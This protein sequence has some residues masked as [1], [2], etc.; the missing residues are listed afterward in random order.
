MM[1]RTVPNI[2]AHYGCSQE[3]AQR[4]MDLRDEGYPMHQALLMAGLSDPP[5]DEPELETSATECYFDPAIAAMH[6]SLDYLAD[7]HMTNVAEVL[8]RPSALVS[9]ESG[10]HPGERFMRVKFTRE[11]V[12]GM[13]AWLEQD[14]ADTV[15]H[16]GRPVPLPRPVEPQPA[17]R[18]YICPVRTVADLANNLLMMDQDLPIYGAQYI[19]HH[20][21][22]R[23]VA[24]SPTVSRERVLASRWIGEGDTLNAAVVWTRAEQPTEAIPSTLPER[25]CSKPSEEQGLF[26]KF[27]VQRTDGSSRPGGRHHDC[28]YFVLDVDHDPHAPAALQAYAAACAESH[29]QLSADLIA[30]HGAQPAQEPLSQVVA[31]INEYYAAL[32]QRKHGGVAQDNAF[33]QIQLALGMT[34]V[35]GASAKGGAA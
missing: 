34:W 19:E 17:E 3:T 20:G 31:A 29:P 9:D 6:C 1:L 23:C 2:V 30:R 18:V 25:D 15:Q 24:V 27:T 33:G 4:Y 8:V 22:R 5:D 11:D 7:G 35:Q 12:Q 14:W 32:D 10:E 28:E 26:H 16:C 21:R 13:L